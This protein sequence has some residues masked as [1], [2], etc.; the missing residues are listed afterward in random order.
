MPVELAL[1]PCHPSNDPKAR[2]RGALPL[3]GSQ[4][5]DIG[6]RDPA[7]VQGSPRLH[8]DAGG[9][10]GQQAVEQQH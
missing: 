7:P 9:Q 2:E 3:R 6:R 1:E 4:G 8:L 5:E 10:P